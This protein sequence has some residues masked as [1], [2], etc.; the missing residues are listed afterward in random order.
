MYDSDFGTVSKLTA[1][2]SAYRS[3]SPLKMLSLGIVPKCVPTFL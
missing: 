1:V 3:F 2:I